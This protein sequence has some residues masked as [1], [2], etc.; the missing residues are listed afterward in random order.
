[1]MDV[2]CSSDIFQVVELM[3]GSIE[4]KDRA[5]NVAVG[6]DQGGEVFVISEKKGIW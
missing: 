6:L 2:V 4:S 3:A 5:P 1:M